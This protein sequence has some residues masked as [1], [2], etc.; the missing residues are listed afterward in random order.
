MIV[1][2]AIKTNYL[3]QEK[4]DFVSDVQGK[5]NGRYFDIHPK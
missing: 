3:G 5:D 4:Y 1:I 2:R